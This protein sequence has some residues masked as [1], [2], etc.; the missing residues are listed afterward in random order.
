MNRIERTYIEYR[1]SNIE[2]ECTKQEIRNRKPQT[3][4]LKKNEDKQ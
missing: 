3:W 4:K 1:T 2:V